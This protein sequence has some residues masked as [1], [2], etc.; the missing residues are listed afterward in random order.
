MSQPCCWNCMNAAFMLYEQADRGRGE[1]G[2]G[3]P[4]PARTHQHHKPRNRETPK[5]TGSGVSLRSH[6]LRNAQSAKRAFQPDRPGRS[7]SVEAQAEGVPRRIE[8]HP[9]GRTG[10][11]LVLGGTEIEYRRLSG[12]EVVDDHVQVHL[13]R[14]LLA[15]PSW[16]GIA[17]HLLE[18][19]ALTVVR[20][21]VSPVGGNLDLPVQQ[22]A[23]ERRES[24]RIGTVDDDAGEACD[25]H[26]GTVQASTDIF[27]P[28]SVRYRPENRPPRL[29]RVQ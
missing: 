25:S 9:E 16:R 18:G 24:A 28:R 22:R 21:D 12:I 17:L 1:A 29:S 5:R 23:V 27:G 15:R 7:R 20:P 10:L 6:A 2:P 8:E 11:V 19:D 13:L 4:E 3:S 14:H 26:A